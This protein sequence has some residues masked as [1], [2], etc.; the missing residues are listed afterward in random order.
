M[1][2]PN[3]VAKSL[4][5][6]EQDSFPNIFI[7]LKIGATIPLTSCECEHSKSAL[8]RLNTY[9]RASMGQEQLTSLE[10]IPINYD[11]KIEEQKVLETFCKKQHILTELD[12]NS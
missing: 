12:F 4:K 2:R 6:C 7:L 10:M 8:R 9:L 1:S 3:S 5:G 11:Q